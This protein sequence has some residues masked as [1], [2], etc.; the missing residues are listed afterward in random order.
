MFVTRHKHMCCP[1]TLQARPTQTKPRGQH[2]A[3]D[4]VFP[5]VHFTSQKSF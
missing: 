2:V 1:T 4:K 3:R 5:S